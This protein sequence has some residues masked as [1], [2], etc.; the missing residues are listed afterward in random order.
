[1]QLAGE[2]LAFFERCFPADF[3]EE[4]NVLDRD[5]GL[6]SDG[7]QEDPLSSSP[8]SW[9]GRKQKKIAPSA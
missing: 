4:P 3:G 8:G 2:L 7:P 9:S 5:G 6:V 1:V